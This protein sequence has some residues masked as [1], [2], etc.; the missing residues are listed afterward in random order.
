MRLRIRSKVF[1]LSFGLVLITLAVAYVAMRLEM[2][3]QLL[4]EIRS[5]LRV[6]TRLVALQADPGVLPLDDLAGWDDWADRLGRHAEARV[7]VIRSDG[8]VLGDSGLSLSRVHAVENHGDRPEIRSALAGDVGQSERYSTTLKTRMIYTAAPF[9]DGPRIAGV[10]RCAFPLTRV[11]RAIE[12]LNSAVLVAAVLALV[13]AMMLSMAGAQLASLTV[14]SLVA[15]AGR[16]AAGELDT[17]VSTQGHDELADLGRALAKLAGNLST[18]LT[19]LRSERDRLGGILH[20]MQEGVLLLDHEG[21]IALV[22]P[23]LREMLLLEADIEGKLPSEALSHPEIQRVLDLTSSTDEPTTHEIGITGLKPRRFLVRVAPLPGETQG[24]FAVFVDVTEMRRLESVRRDF[25]ANVSHELRTPVTAI[26]SAAETLTV[27]LTD[28]PAAAAQF[29]GII[30]RN[31]QR[32]RDL[33]EDVLDLSRIEARQFKIE[34]EP[35]ILEEVLDQIVGLFAERAAKRDI[36][37][38]R[39]SDGQHLAIA[40]RRALENVLTN[41]VDNAIKYCGPGA[42]VS[43]SAHPMA[44][45]IR[46]AV[47]DDGPGI[48]ARHLA[49]IFER[50]YRVDAGRSR[51]L[52]G[53]GLGLSIV[54]HLV[55]A[56][57]GQ[58]GVQSS[59]GEGTTF[60]FTLCPV[61]SK[62]HRHGEG[63]EQRNDTNGIDSN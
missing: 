42:S 54:K 53:T 7:T 31:A 45:S 11:D 32:L 2:E 22:N 24:A 20:G 3:Q 61:E 17:R 23:A 38:R 30:D 12:E 60:S 46:V 25:V 16:M 21:R 33:V 26:R 37:L 4:T 51:E 36:S 35:L 27:A 8:V 50:F 19:E 5:D 44:Q 15:S 14:R 18:T 55:E 49:R 29:V 58:V 34:P 43:I 10:A 13:L 1:V 47:A 6:R 57:G 63:A 48:E 56:M 62:A 9:W 39:S 59:P 52:G 40:D 41:L 28:N